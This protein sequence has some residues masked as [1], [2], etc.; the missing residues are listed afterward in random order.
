[1]VVN[2]LPDGFRLP[3]L[4]GVDAAHRPLQLGELAHH[5]GGEVG[6]GQPA[7]KRRRR[8]RVGFLKRVASDPFGKR[9]DA[10]RLLAIAAELFVKQDRGQPVDARLERRF[11]IRVP[12]EARVAEPRREHTLGIARDDLR[13]L[14]LHVGDREK[15]RLQLAVLVNHRGGNGRRSPTD[16]RRDPAPPAAMPNGPRRTRLP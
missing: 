4:A 5:V 15:R 8:C 6:F 13:L 10:I 11:P 2:R 7:G 3:F 1:M 14:R 16:I 12:E 9:G